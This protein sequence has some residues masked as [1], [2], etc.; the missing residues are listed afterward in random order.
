MSNGLIG[1][2]QERGRIPLLEEQ[3]GT[4]N[5][6]LTD[7]ILR[8]AETRQALASAVGLERHARSNAR[9]CHHPAPTDHVGRVPRVIEPVEVTATV[10]AI[11]QSV[12]P[13]TRAAPRLPPTVR[14]LIRVPLALD[15]RTGVAA[16]ILR[17][18][19]LRSGAVLDPIRK[20]VTRGDRV[21]WFQD[22]SWVFLCALADRAGEFVPLE[23]VNTMFFPGLKPSSIRSTLNRTRAALA[24][25]QA[26][27]D[28][29]LHADCRRGW[30]LLLAERTAP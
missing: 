15:D 30:R 6:A 23:D 9:E 27:G 26:Q 21:G 4:L 24:N 18:L 22:S 1:V 2:R 10:P 5:R 3:V 11:A 16:A 13:V 25:V 7:E 20:A 28:L 8:H 29:E 19:S 17:P 14:P 12:I